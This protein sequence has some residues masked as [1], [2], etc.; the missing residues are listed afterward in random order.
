MEV[1]TKITDIR[2]GTFQVQEGL[3]A[4]WSYG[5]QNKIEWLD[6]LSGTKFA[7]QNFWLKNKDLIK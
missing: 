1:V 2:K 4:D 7:K 6:I 3:N 5:I